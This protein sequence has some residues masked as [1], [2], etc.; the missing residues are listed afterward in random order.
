MGR[1]VS[2]FTQ[3]DL[4]VAR[5]A[6]DSPTSSPK[7]S[8]QLNQSPVRVQHYNVMHKKLASPQRRKTSPTDLKRDIDEKLAKA[9]WNR[10]TKQLEKQSKY[11]KENEKMIDVAER[12]QEKLAMK[13]KQTE[14]K[15]QQASKVE[16][17]FHVTN[18]N[19]IY[20][21]I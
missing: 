21:P 5:S 9:E 16:R 17:S 19:R 7:K 4:N 15:L 14:E 3:I 10:N 11:Q 6:D 2:C 20:Q 8:P 13:Q 12:R 1:H 18:L